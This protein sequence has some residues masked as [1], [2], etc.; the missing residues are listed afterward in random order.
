MELGE[1]SQFVD[2]MHLYSSNS[3][4]L[5]FNMVAAG[6][7]ISIDIMQGFDIDVYVTAF[8]AEL[9]KTGAAYKVIERFEFETGKDRSYITT[10]QQ[11]ERYLPLIAD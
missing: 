7:T 9:Q 10:S 8:L 5:T 4:G 2:S 11:A 6:D 3:R 1:C